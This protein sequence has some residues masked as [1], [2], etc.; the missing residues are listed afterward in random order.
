MSPQFR[1]FARELFA[2]WWGRLWVILAAFSTLATYLPIFLPTFRPYRWVP[3][4]FSA[5]AWLLA[6]YDLYRRKQAE[7]SAL[8]TRISAAGETKSE[9]VIYDKAESQLYV[10]VNA[11]QRNQVI[12]AYLLL[13]LDVENKGARPSIVRRFDLS[14]RETGRTYE[15]IHPER[16]QYLQTR[17]AEHGLRQDWILT[18][19]DVINLPAHGYCTGVLP[20]YLDQAPAYENQEIHCTLTLIDTEGVRATHDFVVRLVA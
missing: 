10:H 8:A 12:G 6:P 2:T 13:H 11:D 18:A 7:I 20:L 17:V 15:N 14:L 3:F 5:L 19:G 4:L 1:Q 16:R 9:L